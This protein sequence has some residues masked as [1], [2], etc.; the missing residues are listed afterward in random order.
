M[1]SLRYSIYV[2]ITD[3]EFIWDSI[4][5]FNVKDAIK[6]F[7]LIYHQL[8]QMTDEKL[9]EHIYLNED[10]QQALWKDYLPTWQ[11]NIK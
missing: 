8:R 9:E 11:R 5:A 7:R 2:D 6:T 3:N 10:K 1:K 4:Y